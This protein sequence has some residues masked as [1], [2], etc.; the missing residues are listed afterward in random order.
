M[1]SIYYSGMYGGHEQIIQGIGT[2]TH[3]T[4]LVGGYR[5]ANFSF[6]SSNVLAEDWFHNGIGRHISIYS[7]NGNKVWEGIVNSVLLNVGSRALKIGPLLDI[8]NRINVGFQH[9]NYNIPGDTNAGL[10]DETGWSVNGESQTRYG[11]LE[12]L[13]SGGSGELIPMKVLRN[14]RLITLAYPKL[15]ESLSS[16]SDALGISIS[17]ECVGYIRLLEKQVY[18]KG[19]EEGLDDVDLSD[20]IRFILNENQFFI[21]NKILRRD[22]QDIGFDVSPIETNNRTAWGIISDHVSKSPTPDNIVCGIFEDMS[23]QL[24]IIETNTTYWRRAG[25][26][27]IFD[28]SQNKI[29]NSELVPGKLMTMLDFSAPMQYRISSV[30]YDMNGDSVSINFHEGSLRTILSGMM[31]GGFFS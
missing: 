2:Y 8:S 24:G 26:T 20:K 21:G 19:W 3:E 14:N 11:V 17:I 15:S 18:N 23:F 28:G 31:L 10:Y 7:K 12:E 16:S 29:E 25:G 9:P 27:T 5:S 6:N 30:K 22:L 1:I 4:T 13:I